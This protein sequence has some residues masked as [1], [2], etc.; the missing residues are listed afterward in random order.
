MTR[1]RALVI[2]DSRNIVGQAERALGEPAHPTVAGIVSALGTY[3]FEV[4][5]VHVALALPRSS[6]RAQLRS[7][8]R[9]NEQFKKDV[10]AHPLGK[11]LVGEL[12][13]H[14]QPDG[15]L[16]VNEKMV[17]TLCAVEIARHAR[18]VRDGNA[19]F[20]AIVVLSKDIDLTPAY[21]YAAELKV[22]VY[23]AATDTVDVRT[24][25]HP[26][27]LLITPDAL[28]TMCPVPDARPR[29]HDLRALLAAAV[30]EQER[31]SWDRA[32][33]IP[34]RGRG[35]LV[36]DTGGEL[37]GTLDP[38]IYPDRLG[39]PA[40]F[41]A[42]DV[43]FGPDYR[44]P[45]AVAKPGS[46]VSGDRLLRSATFQRWVAPSRAQVEMG[47]GKKVELDRLPIGFLTPGTK[48]LI[49][50]RQGR[51]Y[52]GPLET[53]PAL[54]ARGETEPL[55]VRLPKVVE[56]ESITGPGRAV[57]RTEAGMTMLLFAG[58]NV[59]LSPGG[60]HAVMFVGTTRRGSARAVALT[61]SSQ[62][63]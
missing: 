26:Q 53:P 58:K 50:K 33:D 29:G 17:D 10:E 1:P 12:H 22:P 57:A 60:R 16:D 19:D 7:Q 13:A 31:R 5:A 35:E 36:R 45:Y 20:G 11:A 18:D 62:L 8:L 48:L 51:R 49:S 3:G 43:D 38:S 47:N 30:K 34:V 37:I 59:E 32:R 46:K 27:F 54:V 9:V 41:R 2:V 28:A 55:E 63:P 23:A 44:F 56:I 6:D 52:V 15:S 40:D 39:W 61:L 25:H 42:V 4:A 21:Q 14:R 24:S